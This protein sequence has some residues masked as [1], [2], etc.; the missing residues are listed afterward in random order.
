MRDCLL[1]TVLLAAGV[2]SFSALPVFALALAAPCI[3]ACGSK[4]ADPKGDPAKGE[5]AAARL[6]VSCHAVSSSNGNPPSLAQIDN[7]PHYSIVKLRRIMTVPP[8]RT[9][10]RLPFE[11]EE[12]NDLAA[13]IRSLRKPAR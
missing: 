6:C 13:Y 1:G 3:D 7:T 2:R 4:A 11:S 10:H 12:I 8:H 9:M 5:V